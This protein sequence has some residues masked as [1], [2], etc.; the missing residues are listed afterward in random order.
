MKTNEGSD[1]VNLEQAA[2]ANEAFYLAFEGKDYSAMEH[3]WSATREVV[4]LHPGWPALH[5]REAVLASWRSILANPQQGQVSFYGARC[6]QVTT[7]VA[8]VTC[9]EQAGDAVMVAT[10]L[11]AVEDERLRLFSHH[12]GF[13]GNPP[14]E[15][16]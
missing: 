12:A 11:F 15:E 5:G 16:E 4:C 10:N 9:Y 3:L 1:P 13:C 2:F 8:L 6:A 14:A 7:D